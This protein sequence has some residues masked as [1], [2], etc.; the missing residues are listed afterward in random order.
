MEAL[1]GESVV[2]NYPDGLLHVTEEVKW[3]VADLIENINQVS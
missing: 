2:L 3:E 1:G